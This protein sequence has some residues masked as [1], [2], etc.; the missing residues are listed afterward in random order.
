MNL[1]LGPDEVRLL[2]DMLTNHLAELRSEIAHTERYALREELKHDEETIKEL[3]A[4]LAEPKA[5]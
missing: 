2:R 3:L 1:T 4:R 5:A